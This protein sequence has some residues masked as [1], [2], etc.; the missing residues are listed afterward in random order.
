M[1]EQRFDF[2]DQ[3]A[4]FDRFGFVL[5]TTGGEG[6]G[7]I[8]RQSMSSD[9]DHGNSGGIAA[10]AQ[11]AGGVPAVDSGEGHVH[12]DDVRMLTSRHCDGLIAIGCHDNVV[13]AFAETP[14]QKV[15]TDLVIFHQ[16]YFRHRRYRY[17]YLKEKF[18]SR[19]RSNSGA[20]V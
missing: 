2:M 14:G 18:V 10:F 19:F 8:G 16:Q 3:F 5:V 6:A 7:T 12:Q 9:G 20:A 17:H 13:S 15:A 11:L 4:E 1:R